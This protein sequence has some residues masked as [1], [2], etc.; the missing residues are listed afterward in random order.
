[1]KNEG[2]IL[3][4]VLTFFGTILLLVVILFAYLWIKNPF[5]IKDTLFKSSAEKIGSTSQTYDHPGLTDSQES[6]LRSVGIDPAKLPEKL[7][8]E[9]ESC[10][11]AKLGEKRVNEIKA[12]SEIGPL[13]LLKANSCL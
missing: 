8:P 6:L 3:C 9:L 7:T 12:G 4:I 13:D 10:F 1:M 5:G 2:K 11:I